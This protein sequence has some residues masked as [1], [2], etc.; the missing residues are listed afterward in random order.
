MNRKK[1]T[2]RT[3]F[4]YGYIAMALSI[5]A[6]SAAVFL[7]Y[8]LIPEFD[9]GALGIL[10]FLGCSFAGELRMLYSAAGATIFDFF[11]VIL[12]CVV[13]LL[14]IALLSFINIRALRDRR[15][16]PSY[17]NLALFG[18]DALICLIA[19]IATPEKRLIFVFCLLY[20][21]LTIAAQCVSAAI[22]HN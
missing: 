12:V 5:C 4:R 7:L 1:N 22:D 9:A 2:L 10:S 14:Q 16:E 3:L 18:I 8:L 17:F 11:L 20:R 13:M 21:A 15:R 6:G 19:L